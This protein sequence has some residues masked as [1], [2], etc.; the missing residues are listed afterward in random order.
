MI[1][2]GTLPETNWEPIIGDGGQLPLSDVA[3]SAHR[4]NFMGES[5][6]HWLDDTSAVQSNGAR[7]GQR[8]VE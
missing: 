2:S 5:L 3:A 6:A 8:N 4:M 1:E 7:I